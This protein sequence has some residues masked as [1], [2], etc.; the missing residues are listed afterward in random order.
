MN[1]ED[2]YNANL[3]T[4]YHIMRVAEYIFQMIGY[5]QKRILEHDDSK[6]GMMESSIFAEYTKKLAGSTYGSDEY[7]QFLE[8]MSSAL[9]HHYQRNRHHPEHFHDGI[10]GM[11]LIDLIEMLCD[12]KAAPERHDDGDI[13]KSIEINRKR[14]EIDEQLNKIL[15]NTARLFY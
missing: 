3:S 11:T 10:S 6:L 7:K 13:F 8:E 5:L 2:M 14:F 9:K 12:W 4:H 1:H 15:L